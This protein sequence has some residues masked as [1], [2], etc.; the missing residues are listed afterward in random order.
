MLLLSLKLHCPH[1]L[2]DTNSPLRLAC[3]ASAYG[4]GAV[5]SHTMPDG[6]EKPIA[7]ASHTLTKAECNYS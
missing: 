4:V 5:I 1:H 6:P 2:Y 3:D 7:F